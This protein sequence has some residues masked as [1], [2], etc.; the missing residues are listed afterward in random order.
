MRYSQPNALTLLVSG[1]P[2]A[3]SVMDAIILEADAILVKPL[4]IQVLA[5]FIREKMI[6]RKPASLSA[7]RGGALLQRRGPPSSNPG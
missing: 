1:Y 5:E 7:D 4:K 3:R 2:V 6:A